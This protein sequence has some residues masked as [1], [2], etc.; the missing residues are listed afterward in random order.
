MI[1]GLVHRFSLLLTALI[2]LS[3]C[4]SFLSF[5]GQTSRT[6]GSSPSIE[7]LSGGQGHN[8]A[9]PPLPVSRGSDI[10]TSS[11]PLSATKK[12]SFFITRSHSKTMGKKEAVSISLS[13]LFPLYLSLQVSF[14]AHISHSLSCSHTVVPSVLS[15]GGVGGPGVLPAGSDQ[16]PGGHE[17]VLCQ[18]DEHTHW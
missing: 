10:S 5:S 11:P 9:S 16:R 1:T 13:F 18:D 7:S 6:V 14:L 2:C 12:D 17:Q 15:G 4:S 8:T 3:L